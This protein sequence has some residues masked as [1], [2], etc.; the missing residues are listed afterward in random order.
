MKRSDLITPEGTKDLLYEECLNRRNV[1]A[2]LKNVFEAMG[3]SEVVTPGIEFF[4]VFSKKAGYIPQ[5]NLYKLTDTKGRLIVLRPDSTIPIARMVATRLKDKALP[6]RLFYNQT[7]YLNNPLLKGKSDEEVQ[8][9]IEL[10]GSNSKKA[11]LEVLSLAIQS[12]ANYDKKNFRIE[13]GHIGFFTELL[14]KLDVSDDIGEEIRRLIELKNYPALNDLLD[15][16]GDT[17]VTNALKQLPRLFG[18]VEV[19]DKAADL[20]MDD[21]IE[22]ILNNLKDLYIK[23]ENL[24]YNGRITVDL[25]I[26]NKV[27]YYTGVVF[28]GYL[29]GFGEAVLS[30]GRYDNLIKE[31]GLDIPAV[32]FAINVDAIS[33]IIRK[34]G[35]MP[36]VKTPDVIVFGDEGYEI[37]ALNFSKELSEKYDIV[38]NATEDSLEDTKKYAKLMGIK[39]ICVVSDKISYLD[40][41]DGD[42]NE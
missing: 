34:S 11:D 3:Y 38:I 28:R 39:K 4:D 19:F 21:K 6:L 16:I 9:G 31:F 14:S 29:E 32:G 33:K 10:I 17:K 8:I 24:G 42:F 30:G 12:L 5:E 27:N 2:K 23:L 40:L 13:I 1:E 25:G 37:L 26:V 36:E 15:S 20:F 22:E 7:I 18:S 35:R 41:K